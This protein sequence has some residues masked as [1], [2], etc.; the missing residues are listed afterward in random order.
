MKTSYPNEGD[1]IDQR[2]NEIRELWD[3]LEA[4]AAERR[5]QL[6]Q[7]RDISRFHH[8][9]KELVSVFKCTSVAVNYYISNLSP[10][11]TESGY[12]SIPS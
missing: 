3:T 8:E 10:V 12:Q 5:A 4:K 6:E 1:H 11:G 9:T 7:S 2:Q